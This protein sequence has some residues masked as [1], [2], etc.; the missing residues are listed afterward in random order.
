M[1]VILAYVTKFQGDTPDLEYHPVAFDDKRVGHHLKVVQGGSSGSGSIRGAVLVMREYRLDPAVLPFDQVNRLGIEVVPPEV[2]RATK[3]AASVRAVKA[4]REAG[5]DILP[6][7]E[8]GKPFEFSLTDTRGRVIRSTELRG[9]VVLIDCW[10]GWC[11]P[12]MAKMPEL[13]A[14]YE[15]RH[16][17]GF[18][19][20]GVNFDHDR[21]GRGADQDGRVAL[22]RSLR[23]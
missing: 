1:V 10:A 11:S 14:L 20:I 9:K 6:R 4:A 12:C 22:V 18:E 7:P 16:D 5:V 8:V 23:S 21:A 13:K 15:R 17:A 19:V 2:R 3:D